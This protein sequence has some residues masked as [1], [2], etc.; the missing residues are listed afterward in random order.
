MST[1]APTGIEVA[2]FTVRAPESFT[3][4]QH[5]AHDV[6][7]MLRR[8][9]TSLRHRGV[10]DRLFADLVV[11]DSLEAAQIGSGTVREDPRFAP[12]LSSI[13]ELRLY[14]HYRPDVDIGDPVSELRRAPVVELAAYAVRDVG[15]HLE[16]HGRVHNAL[17]TVDGHRGGS[18]EAPR[19]LL[20]LLRHR[21]D[22]GVRALLRSR[23]AMA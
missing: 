17:R 9:R 11:W 1:K 18:P 22:E 15:V 8:Y 16:V 5:R 21:G 14:A 13:A 7:A 19:S 20:L 3:E 23:L 12:L 2:V 6:L 4:L 10:T